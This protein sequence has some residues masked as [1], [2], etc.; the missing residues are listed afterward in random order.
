M[1]IEVKNIVMNYSRLDKDKGIKW[2]LGILIQSNNAEWSLDTQMKNRKGRL[3][4]RQKQVK[5][6][7]LWLFR[8]PKALIEGKNE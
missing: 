3:K 4:D 7:H 2:F 1:T 6:S 5:G 8:V